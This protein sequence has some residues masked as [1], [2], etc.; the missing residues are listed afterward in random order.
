MSVLLKDFHSKYKALAVRIRVRKYHEEIQLVAC[1][2]IRHQLTSKN[3]FIIAATILQWLVQLQTITNLRNLSL[4][5]SISRDLFEGQFHL[6][7]HIAA[8]PRWWFSS[9]MLANIRPSRKCSQTT[10]Y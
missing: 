8:P 6:F 9:R 3:A 1:L 4:S 5:L 10:Y 7:G 2:Q